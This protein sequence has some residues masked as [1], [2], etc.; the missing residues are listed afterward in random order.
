MNEED[1]LDEQWEWGRFLGRG[2]YGSVFLAFQ[3]TDKKRI[4]RAVKVFDMKEDF[5]V[6]AQ[7]TSLLREVKVMK[8]IPGH[9]N[10]VECFGSMFDQRGKLC[11]VMEFM[12]G[13]TLGALLR[14]RAQLNERIA[15]MCVRQVVE[16]VTHLHKQKIF[17]RDLKGDNILVHHIPDGDLLGPLLTAPQLKLADFGNSKMKA[18]EISQ[19]LVATT[20]KT[21]A[22]TALWMAPEVIRAA[23]LTKGYSPAKADV[24]SVGIVAC[25]ILQQGR[26]PWPEFDNAVQA[27]FTI[28]QWNGGKSGNS[29]PPESP[30]NINKEC[31]DFLNQCMVVKAERRPAAEALLRHKWIAS[32]A[33]PTPHDLTHDDLGDATTHET[34]CLR[35][36]SDP[37]VLQKLCLQAGVIEA[38]RKKKSDREDGHNSALESLWTNTSM[39]P[40]P[41]D[42]LYSTDADEGETIGTNDEEDEE[43]FDFEEDEEGEE[44]EYEEDVS[45]E[46]A[47]L[48]TGASID[49]GSGVLGSEEHEFA[50]SLEQGGP[51]QASDTELE[52][53][54][55][56]ALLTAYAFISATGSDSCLVRSWQT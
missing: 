48:Q 51:A 38:A 42:D 40:P 12:G 17:H 26:A 53:A 3:K 44:F 34:T 41:E 21:V 8:S 13:G 35:P 23:Q 55:P 49:R 7:C 52:W 16:G 4:P 10:V 27:L 22:G 15:A 19:S 30:S 24:W 20:A 39:T 46:A 1:A 11:I 25:E 29:L 56:S 5:Q 45:E 32:V 36:V 31:R 54:R 2:S 18:E 9:P 14:S 37:K 6:P 43:D 33:P 47:H 50:T 28:G